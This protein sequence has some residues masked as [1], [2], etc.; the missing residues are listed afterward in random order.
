[1]SAKT[2][3]QRLRQARE[4]LQLDL[5]QAAR[6]TRIRRHYLEALERG[7]F[8]VLP[9]PVQVRGFV[10]AYAAFL[11]LD[12]GELLALLEPK[13]EP[14]PEETIQETAEPAAGE[15]EAIAKQK[16][17]ESA[18]FAS[19]GETLR[20]RRELLE[21][22]H[23]EIE[24]E[25]HIPEHYLQYLEEGEFGRFPS[26]TQARGML[27]IYTDFLGLDSRELLQQYADILQSRFQSRRATPLVLPLSKPNLDL[28][29]F[30]RLKLPPWAKRVLS[31]DLLVGT[32]FTLGLLVFFIWGMGRIS[33]IR[34]QAT[35]EPTA[36][37]LGEIAMASPTLPEEPTA[38]FSPEEDGGPSAET[39]LLPTE[40]TQAEIVVA[41]GNPSEV[42]LQLLASRRVWVRV[43]VDGQVAFEGRL[44]PQ[45]PQA[46]SGQTEILLYT[47]D[48]GSLQVYFNGENLGV[49]GV[50]GEVV[51]MLFTRE[52]RATPTP[53]PTPTPNP[54]QPTPMPS[55]TRQPTATEAVDVGESS[56]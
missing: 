53:T 5:A 51:D 52:G 25:I 3:G 56:P 35:L 46:F 34:A 15:D 39:D 23:A 47:G 29:Q 43:T 4:K 11:E 6:A 40:E 22:T 37:P 13:P 8:D 54:T 33:A 36:P 21:L 10:R 16:E 42:N 18:N 14:A 30:K 45:D 55:A 49:L 27:D 2:L 31:P 50:E 19:I 12:A 38:T 48:A 26:P 41:S 44:A 9:S 7:E 17:M 20:A 28:T 32:L 1:M 24:Q